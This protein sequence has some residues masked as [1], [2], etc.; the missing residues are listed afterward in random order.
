M[1]YVKNLKTARQEQ[2]KFNQELNKTTA[3]LA[4]KGLSTYYE[5]A[6]AYKQI[7]DNAEQKKALNNFAE[8]CGEDA[9]ETRKSFFDS[10]KEI[11]K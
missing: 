4:S 8:L 1:D 2:V 7:G 11:F 9:Y 6:E 3:N 5:L 10:M